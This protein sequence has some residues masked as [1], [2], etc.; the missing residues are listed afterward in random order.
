[1][2]TKEYIQ[3]IW[4][5]ARPVEGLDSKMFRKDACGALIM[6]DKYGK[7]NPFGW[8][9]D[10]IFPQA[11]GGGDDLLNLR[12]LHYLNNRSKSID[13]PSY[14]ACVKFNG[15]TNITEE[16]SLTVNKNIRAKLKKLYTNA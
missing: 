7:Q 4:E 8:E 16:R 5:K 14:I 11:L 12:P 6:F 2:D 10:H 1:M 15:E 3:H 13:Y 9:I